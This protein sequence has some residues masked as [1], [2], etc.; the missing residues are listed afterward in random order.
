MCSYSVLL[1]IRER[2][3][4]VELNGIIKT[5]N[6]PV[7][8]ETA[9][10]DV[11]DIQI[12]RCDDDDEGVLKKTMVAVIERKTVQ[13]FY[14]SIRDGRYAEQKVRFRALTALI[15]LYIIEGDV[16]D[17]VYR[18][19]FPSDYLLQRL[20]RLQ[21]MYNISIVQT[22]N[23]LRTAEYILLLIRKLTNNS[24]V[25]KEEDDTKEET[26]PI[27]KE[28]ISIVK[29]ENMTPATVYYLQLK[30]IP[31]FAGTTVNAIV[32]VYHNLPDLLKSLQTTPEE[33]S[34]I[35][36]NEKRQLGMKAVENM[37]KYLLGVN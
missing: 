32:S 25:C 27:Y 30:Q 4:L 9:S 16:Y 26:S 15:K 5:K 8:I 22:P 36:I 1:D 12:F 35:K 19:K 2:A 21:F 17:S 20:M 37:K 29:K 11:G 13:D 6:L 31:G 10:L 28:S 3:L 33:V 7:N 24:L 34:K 14:S 18:G 23:I